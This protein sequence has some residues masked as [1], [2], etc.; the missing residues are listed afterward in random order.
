MT[1]KDLAKKE[2]EAQKIFD[3]FISA[4]QEK[5]GAVRDAATEA[6]TALNSI[7]ST[8]KTSLKELV[9]IK[10]DTI[11]VANGI[12]QDI[13][14][15]ANKTKSGLDDAYSEVDTVRG[16]TKKLYS[17]FRRTYDAAMN[18]TTGIVA[19]RDDVAKRHDSIKLIHRDVDKLST[20]VQGSA[21]GVKS[22]HAEALADRELVG[23]VKTRAEEIKT[24]IER[25][26]HIT[27]DSAMGGALN[28]RKVEI[29]KDLRFW[30]AALLVAIGLLIAA[31]GLL[32][33][34]SGTGQFG[35]QNFGEA[36]SNRL[37]Y[38]S[39]LA[40]VIFI[41]Y[42]QYGHERRLVEEYAFKSALAQTLRNYAILLSDNYKHVP[43]GEEDILKFLLGT[44]TNIYDRTPLDNTSSFFYQLVVGSKHLGAQATV[45]EGVATEIKT[46]SAKLE[47]T[48]IETT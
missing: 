29:Q 20:E 32:I 37:V 15:S 21:D 31:I 12:S 38:L 45:Q 19:R 34:L 47:S 28:Q 40:F 3:Q 5:K 46:T 27:T 11:K 8:E 35:G 1:V 48:K 33:Y 42:R 6:K 9:K 43:N 18:G 23:E 14:N 26:Y 22:A 30:R 4:T 10:G 13:R 44:M 41:T 17:R 25:T 24:E 39:P 36:V 16:E 2:H 7:R